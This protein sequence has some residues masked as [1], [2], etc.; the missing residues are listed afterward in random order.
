MAGNGAGIKSAQADS[1]DG[2]YTGSCFRDVRAQLLS[3]PYTVLP[4]H[5]VSIGSMF[6]TAKNILLSDSFSLV[7]HDADLVPYMQKLLHAVGICLFGRWTITEDTG[8]TGCFRG[9][10]DH[11]IVV[12]C[13]TLL[14]ATDRGMRRGF[15]FAGKIFPT[16][17]P[18]EIVK[19][20]NFITIDVLGGT[21]A[22]RFSDVKLTNTP[23]FGLNFGLLKLAFV[24]LNIIYVFNRADNAPDY[25]PIY[26]LSEAGLRPGETP[27]GPKWLQ[28]AVEEGIGKSDAVDFRDEL[29]VANYKD[30]KLRFAISAADEKSSQGEQLWRRIGTIELTEDVCSESGDHRIRFRH[31]P[32]RGHATPPK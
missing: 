21:F 16:L 32:N 23:A 13:S 29:R 20:A 10:T 17:D 7:D 22:K 14:S 4:H 8:Y 18:N 15:G 24:M 31:Q 11:L 3:D 28:L 26:A 27:K 1:P 25:R 2:T 5:Q 12:R 9:G 19:T 30:G 6:K